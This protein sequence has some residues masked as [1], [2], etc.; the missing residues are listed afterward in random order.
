LGSASDAGPAFMDLETDPCFQ[1]NVNEQITVD[2]RTLVQ[3]DNRSVAVNVVGMDPQI[4]MGLQADLV[5]SHQREAALH[6]HAGQIQEAA[7]ASEQALRAAAEASHESILAGVQA[8]H[9]AQVSQLQG[10]LESTLAALAQAEKDCK[11]IEQ[12]YTAFVKTA[13]KEVEPIRDQLDQ[14]TQERDQAYRSANDAAL[15][16]NAN[17]EQLREAGAKA[18]E[19]AERLRLAESAA[20]DASL[21]ERAALEK[22]EQVKQVSLKTRRRQQGT[23]MRQSKSAGSSK[24]SSRRR[25]L[26]AMV[27]PA[28]PGLS[29]AVE[30]LFLPPKSVEALPLLT[31]LDSLP[32]SKN[33]NK[34]TMI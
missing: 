22:I 9:A 30:A 5:Q 26:R 3:N 4:G 25:R 6:V 16:A 27:V 19:A 15:N 31:S 2:S 29:M 28:L 17:A 7:A 33:W 20:H 34:R 11:E 18:E 10:Q 23:A 12:H 21:R 32:K 24:I 1:I 8:T 13:R 14:C